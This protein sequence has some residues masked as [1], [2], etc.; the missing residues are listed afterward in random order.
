MQVVG[1]W[2][3]CSVWAL[4]SKVNVVAAEDPSGLD[5]LG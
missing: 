2:W 3:Y 5:D 4:L 1:K